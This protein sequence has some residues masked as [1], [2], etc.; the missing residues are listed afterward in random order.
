MLPAQNQKKKQWPIQKEVKKWDRCTFEFY[1][2]LPARNPVLNH[3]RRDSYS[4][5][6]YHR[7]FQL[8]LGI[9]HTNHVQTFAASL[10]DS[11]S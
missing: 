7:T 4:K 6:I 9:G 2:F 5:V 3:W 8:I 11:I 1:F 10:A